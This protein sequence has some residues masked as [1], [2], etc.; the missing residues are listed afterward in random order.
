VTSALPE[1]FG[2]ALEALAA[3]LTESGLQA[4][5]VGGVAAS[6]LG[7]PRLTQ[8]I[9]VLVDSPDEGWDRLIPLAAPL[10]IAPRIDDPMDFARKTR[11]L[12]LR[13]TTS[14][15]DI[16]V[17]FGALQ[18]E[19]EAVA[20]GT[21]TTVGSTSIRLPRVEDLM[22]MKAIAHRPRDLVDLEG[23][24]LAHPDADIDRVR[25]WVGEFAGAATMPELL[26]DLY[27]LLGRKR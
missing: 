22:I 27:K 19:R 7:R 14:G 24:L 17:V 20:A 4:V 15:I 2:A 21:V 9:D 13:H 5:I 1:S 26:E 8:D 3:F 12:L 25:R 6:L 23:L 18:F 10:G 11:V 16:D